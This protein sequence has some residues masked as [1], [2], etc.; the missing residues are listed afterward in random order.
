MNS[1]FITHSFI[2]FSVILFDMKMLE[3]VYYEP[4]IMQ[5]NKRDRYPKNNLQLWLVAE[6]LSVSCSGVFLR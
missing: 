1:A 5:Q 4:F 3:T 6:G 2:V